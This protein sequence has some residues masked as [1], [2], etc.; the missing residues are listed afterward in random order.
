MAR[1]DLDRDPLTGRRRRRSLGTFRTKKDA[2]AAE[3]RA[4][5]DM[6]RGTD[7]DAKAITIAELL[8]RY[9]HQREADGRCGAKTLERYRDLARLYIVPRIGF[10]L[11]S[12]LRPAHV[13]EMN[14]Y[15]LRRGGRRGKKQIPVPLAP[16]TV[17]H[18]LSLLHGAIEWACRLQLVSRNV[19]DAVEKPKVPHGEAQAI[20]LELIPGLLDVAERS[21]WPYMRQV[22]VLALATGA[23]RGEL[24][25]LKRSDFAED[26]VT[27]TIRRSFSETKAGVTTKPT[28]TER[29]RPVAL[30][31]TA[32]QAVKELVARKERDRLAA[33][34]AYEDHGYLIADALG[35]PLK[36]MHITDT[37]RKIAR[38][39]KLPTTRFHDLRHSCASWLLSEGVDLRTVSSILGH[40]S[41]TTTLRTYAH[42]VVRAQ[43][44]AIEKL[45]AVLRA[46][47]SPRATEWP[48][49]RTRLA[50]KPLNQADSMVAPT[51][52]EPVSPP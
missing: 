20:P 48:P 1:I 27:G 43:Q 44:E 17:C 19:T 3:R 12:K 21:P 51:G 47:I 7:L 14:V 50:G 11:L 18:I 39:A 2:E 36:P 24:A 5:E 38:R 40:T 28:K 31:P 4:L 6:A 41:A 25:A 29:S 22:I 42:L 32:L 10:I 35:R 15:L 30:S 37:F 9:I 49:S 23:R 46:V 34:T 26:G 45:D 16:K 13:A 8:D 33:G 52:V